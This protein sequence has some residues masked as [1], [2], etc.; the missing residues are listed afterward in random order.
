M[1]PARRAG[2]AVLV[3]YTGV[4]LYVTWAWW[5]PLGGR[6]SAVNT[7]DS[8]LFSW[9]LASTPHA[10]GAGELPLYS[11]L[12][13]APTGI[14]LMWNNGMVLPGVL[15]APVTAAFGGLGTVT[16]ITT[17][18][19]AGSAATAF[20]CLRALDVRVLPAAL[21]GALFG[22]SP[23]MLAQAVGGHPNLVFILLVP[24]ILLLALRVLTDDGNRA[25]VLLGVTAGAQVLIGD[26]AQASYALDLPQ[27][28]PIRDATISLNVTNLADV[29]ATSSLVV[30]AASGTY[31]TYP[32]PPRMAFVTL[33]ANF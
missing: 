25:A 30:G 19:L 20:G 15:F 33:S 8:V 1:T 23:A 9:L 10:L 32:L 7:P 13:N 28:L 29:K 16:V 4:A 12:L 22:F 24:V 26:D 11:G 27:N 14:N 18:G 6:T 5:T 17:V 2:A 31:N 21:G 3:A